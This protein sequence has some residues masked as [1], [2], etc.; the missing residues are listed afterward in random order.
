MLV[1]GSWEKSHSVIAIRPPMSRNSP[2]PCILTLKETTNKLPQSKL[3]TQYSMISIL[4][5]KCASGIFSQNHLIW[6]QQGKHRDC[7]HLLLLLAQ[8]TKTLEETAV[9]IHTTKYFKKIRICREGRISYYGLHCS[10]VKI[11]ACFVFL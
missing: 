3:N 7:F 8:E 11:R 5:F 2:V 6:I 1:V 10:S 4:Y 9:I